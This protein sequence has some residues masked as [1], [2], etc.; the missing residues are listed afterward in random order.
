MTVVKERPSSLSQATG[1]L[2]KRSASFDSR[3]HSFPLFGRRS[4]AAS[5]KIQVRL[6]PNF[7]LV[8]EES[9]KP[10]PVNVE[11]VINY[12]GNTELS[13]DSSFLPERPFVP[14][15]GQRGKL[16][17]ELL[18]EAEDFVPV[19]KRRLHFSQPQDPKLLEPRVATLVKQPELSETSPIQ[20][21]PLTAAQATE[22][23]IPR[24]KFAAAYTTSAVVAPFAVLS[25]RPLKTAPVSPKVEE[26]KEL[27]NKTASFS[28]PRPTAVFF[29]DPKVLQS[30]NSSRALQS[31]SSDTY[32]DFQAA[33]YQSSKT[34]F[35][36]SPAKNQQKVVPDTDVRPKPVAV[37]FNSPLPDYAYTVKSTSHQPLP[38]Q[39]KEVLLTSSSDTGAAGGKSS[40][41]D[42]SGGNKSAD[43]TGD[44]PFKKFKAETS[45]KSRTSIVRRES[46]ALRFYRNKQISAAKEAESTEPGVYSAPTS[47]TTPS[48]ISAELQG[49][50]EAEEGKPTEPVV[51]QSTLKSL[52]VTKETPS[53]ETP[54]V[55]ST[56]FSN[57]PNIVE[58]PK[59]TTQAVRRFPVVKTTEFR[60]NPLRKMPVGERSSPAQFAKEEFME[61]LNAEESPT[62]AHWN[63]RLLINKLYEVSILKALLSSSSLF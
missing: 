22:T 40:V 7:G 51:V 28:P 48:P 1:A 61:Q 35:Q 57:S 17:H 24:F 34:D 38:R 46:A 8:E 4:N 6:S 3:F 37:S 56:S 62:C 12:T 39:V 43:L 54:A 19:S 29:A 53:K 2:L 52:K 63:P 45:R 58:T 20:Q 23:V 32:R 13:P 31:P 16:E 36:Y 49:I 59:S 21:S 18:V 15:I 33:A 26:P 44:T 55:Q 50:T 42:V 47:I 10:L 30:N 25:E 5:E 14:S 60:N 27:E 41:A 9:S 11:D